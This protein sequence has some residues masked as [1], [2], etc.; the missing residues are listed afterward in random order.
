M[1]EESKGYKAAQMIYHHDIISL[2]NSSG[3]AGALLIKSIL[4]SCFALAREAGRHFVLENDM[5][6]N[7]C[8][9]CGKNFWTSDDDQ[10]I[11]YTCFFQIDRAVAE[12][13]KQEAVKP[14]PVVERKP[15]Q[16]PKKWTRETHPK[17][18][19]EPTLRDLSVSERQ[20]ERARQAEI[21]ERNQLAGFVYLMRSG[22]GFYKI[23]ISKKVDRR[24][25]D[26]K[27]QFP[28]EIEVVHYFACHDRRAVESKLHSKYASKRA[29]HEWFRLEP[30]DVSYIKSIKDYKLG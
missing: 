21:Y 29:Q 24:L 13:A 4:P 19:Y 26:L 22:N 6:V 23:G 16:H 2:F 15:I 14:V 30:E 8:S 12:I 28:I 18:T 1:E 27:R 17:P 25:D 5:R 20:K 11:C 9:S 10:T 3:L 7:T